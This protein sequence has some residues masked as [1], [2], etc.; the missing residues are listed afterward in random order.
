MLFR[1]LISSSEIVPIKHRDFETRVSS[2]TSAPSSSIIDEDA[3]FHADYTISPANPQLLS[4]FALTL[5]VLFSLQCQHILPAAQCRTS[6]AAAAGDLTVCMKDGLDLSIWD[7]VDVKEKWEKYL[8]H[9][10]QLSAAATAIA[11]EQLEKKMPFNEDTGMSPQIQHATQHGEPQPQQL[12][13]P[14]LK[15]VNNGDKSNGALSGAQSS[16]TKWSEV[17]SST[18]NAKDAAVAS[19]Q[20]SVGASASAGVEANGGVWKS[21]RAAA[22]MSSAA[23]SAP[24]T[25]AVVAATAAAAATATTTAAG[26]IDVDFDVDGCEGDEDGEHV[27]IDEYKEIKLVTALYRFFKV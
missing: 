19:L 20:A 27:V 4:P 1:S 21:K 13:Q 24:G 26:S 14:P 6:V 18:I 25:G 22:A 10:R 23:M 3:P 9:Q 8:Q 2:P 16:G 5:L 7:A 12:Q 17:A 11:F 15:S